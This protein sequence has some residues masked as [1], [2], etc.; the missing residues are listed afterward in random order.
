MLAKLQMRLVAIGYQDSASVFSANTIKKLQTN[1]SAKRQTHFSNNSP[2]SKYIKLLKLPYFGSE[3][4]YLT[5]RSSLAPYR[6]FTV[7]GI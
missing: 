1:T 5:N 7:Y 4:A 3:S 2:I 6:K